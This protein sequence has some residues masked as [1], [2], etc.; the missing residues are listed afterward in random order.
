MKYA[1]VGSRSF[2]DRELMDRV[3]DDVIGAGPSSHAN[4]VVSGGAEGADRLATD[5]AFRR[6]VPCIEH[7]P[8]VARYGSP[9]AFFERNSL[10]VADADAVIAF[11]GPGEPVSVNKGGTM[12]TVRKAIAARKPV[13]LYFQP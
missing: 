11:F 4:T 3:L 2:T 12:D 9:R 1:V 10:I 7:L 8:D 13:L 6:N 5:W